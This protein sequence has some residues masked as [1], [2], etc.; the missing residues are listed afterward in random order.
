MRS[1][2][3]IPAKVTLGLGSIVFLFLGAPG[4]ASAANV[5]VVTV[6]GLY[7]SPAVVNINPGDS[8]TWTNSGGGIEP[9]NVVADDGSFRCA[10]GCDGDG[11]G[12]DG[13]FSN[14]VWSFTITFNQ[15]GIN[16]YFCEI[17]GG[18]GGVGM[19]GVVKVGELMPGRVAL[20]K[21]GARPRAKFVAKPLPGE[22][23]SLPGA[24]DD[25][26]VTGG[27]LRIFDTIAG[28]GD[29]NYALPVQAAPLG[30]KGLGDPPGSR[31]FKYRGAGTLGDPCKVVV[32]KS[33]AV[34]AVCKDAGVTLAPPFVGDAGIVLTVGAKPYCARFGG[35]TKSNGTEL[36]KRKN[37]PAPSTCPGA[38]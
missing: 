2:G 10:N 24:A 7:F 3:L 12:G 21:P 33:T 15:T 6:S 28:A 25:P 23:F 13:M 4:T 18:F 32:I 36:F 11:M 27:S 16:P 34:K 26:T 37:A 19:A 38:P 35:D 20:V 1:K 14:A 30:W 29:N 5:N 9:H 22:L 8:V 17:H 31:G